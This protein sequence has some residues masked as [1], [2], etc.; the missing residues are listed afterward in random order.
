MN[1]RQPLVTMTKAA[2]ATMDR[3]DV[4]IEEFP[5]SRSAAEQR[6]ECVPTLPSGREE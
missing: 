1:S 5:P 6:E 3:R 2:S 4:I